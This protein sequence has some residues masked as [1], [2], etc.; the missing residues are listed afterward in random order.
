MYQEAVEKSM[1]LGWQKFYDA[2]NASLK[3]IKP[4]LNRVCLPPNIQ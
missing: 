1:E 4:S 3:L 2:T